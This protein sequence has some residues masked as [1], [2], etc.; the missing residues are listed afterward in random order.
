MNKKY[1]RFIAITSTAC[2]LIF[3]SI[4]VSGCL[5]VGPEIKRDALLK[6]GYAIE[7]ADGFG[8]GY[9]SGLSAGGNPRA[10]ITKNIDRYVADAKYKMGW[11]DGFTSGKGFM[12]N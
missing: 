6:R 12:E 2:T 3:S 4:V 7:Y 9:V 11:D 1:T 8:D 10:Q 5:S